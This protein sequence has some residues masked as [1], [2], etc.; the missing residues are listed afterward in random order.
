LAKGDLGGFLRG[1]IT[2][3]S[4]LSQDPGSGPDGK[5]TIKINDPCGGKEGFL[6]I[7]EK[8]CPAVRSFGEGITIEGIEIS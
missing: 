2:T 8:R 3:R 6:A 4:C 1:R 5:K 7:E